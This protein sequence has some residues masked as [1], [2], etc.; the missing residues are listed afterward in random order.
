M[1][2]HRSVKFRLSLTPIVQYNCVIKMECFSDHAIHGTP[3]TPVNSGNAFRVLAHRCDPRIISGHSAGEA[4][5]D[6]SRYTLL[7]LTLLQTL[8]S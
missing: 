1:L 6:E 2:S 3:R 5:V 8:H 7:T 4:V